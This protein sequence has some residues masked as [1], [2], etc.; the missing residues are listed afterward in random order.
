[1]AIAP[2][3]VTGLWANGHSFRECYTIEREAKGSPTVLSLLESVIAH[4]RSIAVK[5]CFRQ[6]CVDREL[7][8]TEQELSLRAKNTELTCQS[9][10]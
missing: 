7:R 3:S 8:S 4:A 9:F 10:C 2:G 1:M 5:N 6:W